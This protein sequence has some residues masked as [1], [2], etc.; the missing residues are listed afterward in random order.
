MTL[1]LNA[2]G[3]LAIGPAVFPTLPSIGEGLRAGRHAGL[4]G[5][6]LA[7]HRRSRKDASGW[8]RPPKP[9]RTS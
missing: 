1:R 9:I 3:S 6:Y 2:L 8:R 5:A 7:A 4:L